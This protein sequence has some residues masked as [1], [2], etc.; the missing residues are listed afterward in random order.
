[1]YKLR[2][3][4]R[5]YYF[6]QITAMFL[7]ICLFFGPT[8]ILLASTN[9]GADALP[10]GVINS[11]GIGSFD[12]I[13]NQLNITQI[14]G[15]AVINWNNFDIGT[16]SAV[17]FIQPGSTAA[18]LNRV[19]DGSPTGIMGSLTAN[20]SV[21]VVNPAGV[22]FGAG[23]SVNVA[24]LVASSLN[25]A[26]EDFI[27][28]RYDFTG[29]GIGEITN[30]GSIEAAK[31]VALIG[32]KVLNAGSITTKEGGFVVMT[33]G[34]RVLLGQPGSKIVVEMS[35][36]SSE[37]PGSGDVINAG[38]IDSDDGTIVLASG[39]LFSMAAEL[40]SAPAKIKTGT[41]RVVQ[42]GNINAGS[43]NVTLTAADEVILTDGSLTS[44][45]GGIN[46]DGGEI[47][48]FSGGMADFQAGA[49]IEAKGGS[50]SGNG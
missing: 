26:D 7:A 27:N 16:N 30:Y 22:V 21:F 29:S 37:L 12:G 3:I 10:S 19:H 50:E 47:I 36:V 24:Q 25:I 40:D 45:N 20:G 11:S 39:D 28:G 35:S 44:A 1:M 33:A 15:E 31:G 18:V 41:G 38:Q 4:S 14:A 6:R 34:D 32:Q 8:T 43:G 49:M 17:K 13:A 2:K 48:V 9:P 46:G 23:S 42:S 5:K